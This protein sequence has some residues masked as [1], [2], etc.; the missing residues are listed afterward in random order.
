[1]GAQVEA[2][3]SALQRKRVFVGGMQDRFVGFKRRLELV[4]LDLVFMTSPYDSAVVR[5]VAK[6][7]E[8]RTMA[9]GRNG[10]VV[11][12]SARCN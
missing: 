9:L 8:C 2:T 12:I 1:M 4:R 3:P 6:N 7:A 10:T 5:D 11:I